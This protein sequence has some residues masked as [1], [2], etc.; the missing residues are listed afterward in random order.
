MKA[1]KRVHLLF[2]F[3]VIAQTLT[4]FITASAQSQQG[5]SATSANHK[6]ALQVA[7]FD[8]S[9]AIDARLDEEVWQHATTLKDFVQTQPGDNTPASRSTEVLLGYDE[10][11]LY[12]GIQAQDE[13]DKIRATVAKR[14]DV[15]KDDYISIYLDTFND[16]R[17]AYLL[18]FNPLGV[19]QDGIYSEGQEPDYSVDIV[20]QSK[21]LV[22]EK[23]YTI[24][25]AIPLK[26]LR[27][28]TGKDKSWG[29]QVQRRIKHLNDEE[30]SWMPLVRGQAG[31]LIQAGRITG[32]ENIASGR[33]LEIIPSLTISETGRRVPAA[34]P[35]PLPNSITGRLVNQPAGVDT[36][37]TM[38]LGV[39]PNIT[40]DL[41]LNPDFAQVEADQTVVT[42]NQRFPLFFEEKRP[43][44]LEGIDIFQTPLKVVHTRTIIDPDI[45]LKLSGKRERNTFGLLLATD[46][47]PGNF[48]EEERNDPTLYPTI[49]R[50]I[51][52]KAYIGILRLKRDFGQESNMGLIATSYNFIEKHNQL[53]GMDGRFSLNQQNIITFQALGTTSRR[54]F[55]DPETDRSTYRTGNGFGYFSQY[56][57][58]GRHLNVTLSGNGRTP[59]YVADVGFTSRTDTNAWDSNIRYNSEPKPESQLISWSVASSSHMQFDW[60]GRSQYSYQA[61]RSAFNFKHQTYLKADVYSDYARIF[62]EEFG[63]KR[64][65]QRQG[66]FLGA[67]ERSTVWQGFTIEAGATP[68]KKYSAT[69]IYDRSWNAFDY[70]FGAGAKFPRV[71]PA[72]LIDP[73]AP[74]DPGYG[75][76]TDIV[77]SFNW[78]PTD[79]LRT[80]L[81]YTKSRLVRDD[82]KLVA[83]DQ[84]IYSLRSTYQFTPFT[85]ARV[86]VD[87]DSLSANIRAQLLAGWTPNPGTSFYIGYNDDLNYNGF[88]PFTG[89]LEKGFQRN[90][91][92]FFIKMSYLFRRNI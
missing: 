29:I 22:T 47:A 38:K 2:I 75:D 13:A 49:E 53:F 25:V 59:D 62:E 44:F 86:R 30:D 65:A 1:I 9:P 82:T 5:T 21:G 89:Y 34:V 63:A 58:T 60:K 69:I 40:L 28:D 20:M 12:V 43:F 71:S 87:Y 23:G 15:L 52:K 37:V 10:H 84:N 51:D 73:Y 36:G 77:A 70:D 8:K 78:Q 39:T 33:A 19:Q 68:S 91:R 66:A 81:S 35:G 14:D 76:T 32:F 7:R 85:F 18:I 54:F 42:A 16:K 11:F 55:Y 83:Y 67:P 4:T 57:R 72:A 3:A 92:T 56:Q 80:S 64:T 74:I 45:A 90:R 50:F 24:E 61:W 27:Y 79:A 48:A 6:K 46:N 17:R 26:S 88:S 41:A 31:F